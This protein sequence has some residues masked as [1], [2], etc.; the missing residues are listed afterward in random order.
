M[1]F[2]GIESSRQRCVS[3]TDNLVRSDSSMTIYAALPLPQVRE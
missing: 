2:W 3:E 1:R